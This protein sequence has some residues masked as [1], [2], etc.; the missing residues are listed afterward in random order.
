MKNLKKQDI[1]WTGPPFLT[2]TDT[3]PEYCPTKSKN[4]NALY[5]AEQLPV[6]N[7]GLPDIERYGELKELLRITSYVLR[8]FHKSRGMD[9]YSTISVRVA[10]MERAEICW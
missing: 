10:E 2:N 1:W 6:I 7:E 8:V 4:A 5:V 9:K 3:W